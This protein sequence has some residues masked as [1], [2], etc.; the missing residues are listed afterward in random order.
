[1]TPDAAARTAAALPI[2]TGPVD[3]QPLAGGITNL[4]FIVADAGRRYLV[5]IGGDIPAHMIVRATE[6]AASRAAH[7][8]GLAPAV[9]HWQPGALV[10][11][12]IDGRP[13][14]PGRRPRRRQP[15]PPRRAPAPLPPRDPQH[16]RGPAPLFWVF[17][18]VRDYAHTLRDATPPELASPP[19]RRWK[20][21]SARSRSSSATTTSCP[22]T[23]STTAPGSG[24]S[25]GNTPASTRPLFDL[26][27]LASN[28]GMDAGETAALL[29][30]Y[31]GRA[32]R[33]RAPPPRRGDDRRLAVA[34][35]ALEHGLRAPLR[36]RLRL[37]RPTPPRTAPASTP[38]SPPSG[39]MP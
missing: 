20:P 32:A 17:Q 4:N 29:E 15:P 30:A 22:P 9:R 3:P 19:P 8:A 7:A 2:W 14:T 23:S 13:L 28:A 37:C 12:F 33:R 27:G 31:F 10:L 38:P 36:H 11:D 34:R 1:M 6:L 35:D 18:V 26:G 24:W 25:I 16:F 21:P 39:S 5:R